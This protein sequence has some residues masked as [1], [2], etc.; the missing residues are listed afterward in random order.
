[1]RVPTAEKLG[2]GKVITEQL[3]T[4]IAEAA[5]TDVKPRTSWRA[6]K[7]FRMQLIKE[8]CKRSLRTSIK[9]AGGTI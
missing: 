2:N 1:M 5:L 4:D 9:K 3:I 8:L 7:E 6:S